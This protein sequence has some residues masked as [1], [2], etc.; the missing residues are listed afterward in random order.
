MED[1]TNIQKEHECNDSDCL[2]Q[3]IGRLLEGYTKP[4]VEQVKSAFC[5]NRT[6]ENQTEGKYHAEPTPAHTAHSDNTSSS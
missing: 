4:M 2:C 6:G 5:P 3:L 1:H